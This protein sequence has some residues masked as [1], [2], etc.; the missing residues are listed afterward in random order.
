MKF[1]K[2][3]DYLNLKEELRSK[4]ISIRNHVENSI[5]GSVIYGAGYSGKK[6][7]ELMSSFDNNN[8]SYFID[9]DLNKVG[10]SI[11][12]IKVISFKDFQEI[13]KIS[14]IRNVIF[15]IPSL[16]SKK[17]LELIRKTMPYCESISTLPEKSLIKNNRIE[18]TDIN[19]VS[20]DELFGKKTLNVEHPIIKKFKNSRILI[21]GGAGSIG[22]ELTSQIIK[23]KPKVILVLDHSELNIYKISKILDIKDFNKVKLILG[24]I[25]DRELV[26][27]I[28]DKYKIDYIFHAAAYKHVKF[29]EGNVKSAVKNNVLGTYNLIKA[30]KGKKINFVFIST[31]KAVNP[32][33][34]LGIT[35]RIGEI[36]T[37]IIFS[38]R[39]YK[40]NKF[41]ILRFGNVI[42]SDGSAL[43][44]F[45]NQ[46]KN[47]QTITL[48]DRNMSRYFMSIKE[49][50]NLVLKSAVSKYINKTFF[51][52][53]GKP[54]KI[55][56]IIN[57]MFKV[58]AKVD[59][60]LKIKII[61][62]KFNEKLSE[63]LFY[64][65]K[66]NKTS[67][68]KV[69][70][71]SDNIL[72]KKKFIKDLDNII[73]KINSVSDNDLKISLKKIIKIK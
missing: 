71:V 9:D 14:S 40:N 47:N 7:A 43:P 49:A 16:N 32:K 51:L 41:F 6:I 59:Q 10:K 42:G 13:S 44:L 36:L 58:Y 35:N 17:R 28:I 48:T 4:K 12:N 11:N 20:F 50:C 24:D 73:L 55:I 63:K 23:S 2:I 27:D 22:A 72:N 46:I 61:G 3:E 5:L 53:M 54:I 18:L 62:N 69:F 66:V 56:D 38:Q 21:T 65:H 68:K 15:A 29:L 31:Y 8:I 37:Q 30:I 19:D 57:R 25:K 64:N 33:N 60:K 52:D 70:T 34:I 1:K 39:D 26:S 45:L 67:I